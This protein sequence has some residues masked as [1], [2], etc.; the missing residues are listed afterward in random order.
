MR[1]VCLAKCPTPGRWKRVDRA[2]LCDGNSITNSGFSPNLMLI[3]VD[4]PKCGS[5]VEFEAARAGMEEVCP[6]CRFPLIVPKRG[7]G[8]GTVVG[9]FRIESLLGRGGMGDV[10][11]AYQPSMDR[12]VALKI[13]PSRLTAD[14]ELVRRFLQEVRLGARLEHP[15]L[16]ATHE[17]GEDQGVY[18]MAMAYVKGETLEELVLREGPLSEKSVLEIARGV[19]SAL[20]YCWQEHRIL[21]RDI[22][23]SNIMLDQYGSVRVM[24]MG[25]SMMVGTKSELTLDDTLIGTPNYMSPEQI[26]D[27]RRVD[28]RSDMYSLGAT[29]YFALTAQVPF[30]GATIAETVRKQM[31]GGLP[32]PRTYAPKLSEPC[33]SLLEVM[34]ACEARARHPDWPALSEDIRRVQLGKRPQ[35]TLPR[36]AKSV[37]RR[38]RDE[39]YGHALAVSRPIRTA[40]GTAT[41]KKFSTRRRAFLPQERSSPTSKALAILW[42]LMLAGGAVAFYQATRSWQERE[43]R[44]AAM[45]AAELRQRHM[46]AVQRQERAK[47]QQQF[48]EALQFARSRT[49]DPASAL[50]RFEELVPKVAGTELEETVRSHVAALR[51]IESTRKRLLTTARSLAQA[52]KLEEAIEFLHSYDGPHAMVLREPRVALMA[53]LSEE[54]IRQ[55]EI[56]LSQI[57]KA[58]R[59]AVGR[60]DALVTELADLLLRFDFAAA[61]RRA[62][63]AELDDSF[64]LVAEMRDRVCR[65]ARAVAKLPTLVLNSYERDRGL[66]IPVGLKRG[67]ETLQIWTVEAGKVQAARI[68]RPGW[69]VAV[70]HPT[71]FSYEDLTTRE[72]MARLGTAPGE[73]RDI[74]RGLLSFEAGAYDSA[75]K[76]FRNASSP[77]VQV[78]EQKIALRLGAGITAATENLSR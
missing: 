59:Q 70:A 7:I 17:A 54:L 10:Y 77:L 31:E 66:E 21:H 39:R 15:N 52:G 57:E 19:A 42:L 36:N 62:A 13:L 6:R 4:C 24:D 38:R 48:E 25:I 53:E 14:E 5:K 33:V 64:R 73:E 32:D 63:E 49:N 1:A 43:E 60:L 2:K 67:T 74:M 65:T 61:D 26:E 71:S 44:L 11:L 76:Y 23:P 51:E 3:L 50:A 78:L 47:L 58:Q 41:P 34:L 22:K 9:G 46:E 27:S 20:Q 56:E 16:L 30:K 35:H 18:Y 12:Y 29:L 8:P 28:I 45:R 69:G 68:E 72:K 55:R 37:M 75:Q 40:N